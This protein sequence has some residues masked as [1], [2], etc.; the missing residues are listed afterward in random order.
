MNPEITTNH[1]LLDT[2]EKTWHLIQRDKNHFQNRVDA[3]GSQHVASLD[4]YSWGGYNECKPDL[5]ECL[6]SIW[7][8][9]LNKSARIYYSRKLQQVSAGIES[10]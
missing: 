3:E 1:F 5:A 7:S 10:D 6:S 2:R 9:F 8:R 4:S